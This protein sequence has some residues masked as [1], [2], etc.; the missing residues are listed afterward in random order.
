MIVTR[1]SEVENSLR[2]RSRIETV[3]DHLEAHEKIELPV[4]R[5]KLVSRGALK[6]DF[7]V[8]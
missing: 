8:F 6:L 2:E 5:S 4:S 1:F 3:L 7:T